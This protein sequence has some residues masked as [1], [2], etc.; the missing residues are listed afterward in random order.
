MT[1]A[2]HA[3]HGYITDKDKYLNRLKRIEGQARGISKMVDDEKYCID[4]LTQI[5]ALTSALQAVALGLLD[6]H[7]K[8]C[9]LD[10]ARMGGD[11]AEV[12]IKEASDA[13]ARLV[14]S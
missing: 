9:V 1:D 8:H 5:S 7:L 12:K 11:E 2:T 14:R 3:H 13:I 4:I 6:D 10:A